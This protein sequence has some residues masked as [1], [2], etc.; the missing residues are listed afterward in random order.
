M[1][2]ISFIVD[3]IAWHDMTFIDPEMYERQVEVILQHQYL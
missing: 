2:I 3:L 1:V